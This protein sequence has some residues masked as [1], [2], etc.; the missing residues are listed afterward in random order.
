MIRKFSY[1]LQCFQ[2][3]CERREKAEELKL[4]EL[5]ARRQRLEDEKN[6]LED[7]VARTRKSIS[8]ETQMFSH[9]VQ[10]YLN[11]IN[12]LLARIRELETETLKLDQ[13]IEKQTETLWNVRKQ[14]KPVEKLGERRKQQFV[15]EMG[16]LEQAEAD[17][18][19][20]RQLFQ[21]KHTSG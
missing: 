21:S 5:Y 4:R 7:S 12:G 3:L 19:Y 9:E 18:Q 8:G 2:D 15:Q 17:D 13:L 11:H 14:K 20:L 1:R 16:R 6:H 10:I